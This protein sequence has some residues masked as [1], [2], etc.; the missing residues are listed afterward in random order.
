MSTLPHAT[1]DRLATTAATAD[2]YRRSV[3][4]HHWLGF[5]LV[6]TAYVSINVRVLF[7]KGTPERLLAVESHFMAGLAILVLA[8]PRLFNRL[9]AG[10]PAI[11]PPL[12]R[13]NRILSAAVQGALYAFLIVEP[14]LGVITRMAAGRDIGLPFTDAAIPSIL[15]AN[16]QLAHTCETVHIWL[17]EAFYYVIGLHILA[18]LWHLLVRRDD[19]L[20]RMA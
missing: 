14:V 18:A 15:A 13:P 19:T 3:R 5:A 10:T 6:V 7:A 12:S 17:A 11:R 8:L 9:H 20:Q 2:K 1:S 16:P 4:L